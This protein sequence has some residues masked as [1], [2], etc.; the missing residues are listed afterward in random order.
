[1]ERNF[2]HGAPNSEARKRQQEALGINTEPRLYTD[3]HP[4]IDPPSTKEQ[5]H[6]HNVQLLPPGTI[7]KGR[8]VHP[9][10]GLNGRG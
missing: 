10:R 1:M 9:R 8:V 6:Q 2:N 5:R 3:F 4:L 7:Y